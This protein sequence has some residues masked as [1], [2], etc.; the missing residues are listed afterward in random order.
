LDGDVIAIIGLLLVLLVLLAPFPIARLLIRNTLWKKRRVILTA[1]AVSPALIV[2]LVICLAATF[3]LS[4]GSSIGTVSGPMLSSVP[5]VALAVLLFG[6]GLV[7]AAIAERTA[8]SRRV[9]KR[10]DLNKIFE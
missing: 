1:A 6:I 10:N 7:V 4:K 2:V 3:A 8:P 5:G 9:D